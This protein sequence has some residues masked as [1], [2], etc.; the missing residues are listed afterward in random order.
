MKQE[1]VLRWCFPAILLVGLTVLSSCKH[2]M[3]DYVKKPYNV[4]DEERVR[5]AEE[6]L[7][8]TIDPNQDWILTSEYSVTITANANL[9]NISKVAVLDGNPYAGASCVLATATAT[10]GKTVTLSFRAPTDSLLYAACLTNNGKCIARAF[11][12]G[13][14]Q[15]VSFSIAPGAYD[16]NEAA[17]RSVGEIDDVINPPTYKKFRIKDF[18]NFRN[19]LLLN[20]PDKQNNTDKLTSDYG[21]K[22][23]VAYND[24]NFYELPLVFLGGLGK[25]NFETDNDNL[26]YV[27]TYSKEGEGFTNRFLLKDHFKNAF[28]PS[29]NKATN[30]YAVEGMYLMALDGAGKPV[31]QFGPQDIVYF[32]MYVG[33]NPIDEYD[34][35]RVKVFQMNGEVFVACEDGDDWDFNDRLFWFPYGTANIQPVKDP[36]GPIPSGPQVWTYAWEDRDFGDYDLN[37]CVIQ[38]WENIHDKNL[39][40]I[41]LVALGAT[42][43]LW[44]GFDNKNAQTYNDYLHVFEQELHSVLG[45]PVGKMANTENGTMTVSPVKV[46]IAKPAGFDFQKCS[47]ILGAK[48][49]QDMQG[50]YESD[51][52]AIKIAQK[53]QDP[54]GIVIPGRWQWP[55]EK[56]C[57]TNAYSK[58]ADWAHDI[59]D[60]TSKNWYMYPVT[61]KVVNQ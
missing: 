3:D 11:Q 38:V 22:V 44:L 17:A 26:G 19:A 10:N 45:I 30:S 56:V 34:G 42:R 27:W 31:T 51:Y 13:Q 35:Q 9:S 18:F 12:P 6:K 8:V 59:K 15:K 55:K 48:V 61:N 39:L 36:F 43:E 14:E 57:I 7:G 29:Y 2:D 32:R 24:F 5:Y 4:T 25:P 58:F 16:D 1:E 53:G 23:Q 37:D 54:H 33:E 28:Q 60:P 46:T 50:V 40:D 49:E 52:Y 47:F 21:S 20:L 41:T